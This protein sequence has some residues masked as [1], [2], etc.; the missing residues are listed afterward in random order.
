MSGSLPAS[1]LIYLT[2]FSLLG[3]ISRLPLN[4]LLRL[5]CTANQIIGSLEHMLLECKYLSE[6]LIGIMDLWNKSLQHNPN[7][8]PILRQYTEVEPDK[9][10]QFMLDPSPLP[11]V[12]LAKQQFGQEAINTL[13]HLTHTYCYALHKSK[14]KQLGIF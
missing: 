2:Q 7:L 14:M 12:I 3:M 4:I 8:L 6:T 13:F 1:A 5:D 11:L 10:I 9:A